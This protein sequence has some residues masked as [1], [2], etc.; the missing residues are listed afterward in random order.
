MYNKRIKKI[1]MVPFYKVQVFAYIF[2][3]SKCSKT[4]LPKIL[5]R[6]I[7]EQQNVQ[8]QQNLEEQI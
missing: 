5:L 2:T 6:K 8:K 7:L 4:R 1:K 3:T